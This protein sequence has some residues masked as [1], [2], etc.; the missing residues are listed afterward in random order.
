MLHL[1]DHQALE[2][3]RRRG[4]GIDRCCSSQGR[5]AGGEVAA[6]NVGCDEA[7][8]PVVEHPESTTT[9]VAT[10]HVVVVGLVSRRGRWPRTSRRRTLEAIAEWGRHRP[11]P[12]RPGRHAGRGRLGHALHRTGGI[13]SESRLETLVGRVEPEVLVEVV[14]PSAQLVAGQLP[15][16]AP[17]PPCLVDRPREHRL[18]QT[19]ASNSVSNEFSTLAGLNASFSRLRGKERDRVLQ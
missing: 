12:A 6:H 5:L 18:A 1:G 14:C 11:A 13:G 15:Q 16:R 2:W 9:A 8:S 19:T 3:S 7:D 10:H 17:T 4:H